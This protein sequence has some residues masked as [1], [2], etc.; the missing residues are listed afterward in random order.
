MSQYNVNKVILIGQLGMKPELRHSAK[1][2]PVVNLSIAT[3]RSQKNAEGEW[4]ESTEWHRA[5]VWGKRAE[6]CD[7]YLHKGSRVYVE[8]V[9]Q[10][11]SWTDTGGAKHWRTEVLVDEIKFLGSPLKGALAAQEGKEAD[12]STATAADHSAYTE[13]AAS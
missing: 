11:N 12:H 9:I 2:H 4:K 6:A 7:R 3:H 8:G 10:T 1:G 13:A 5:V